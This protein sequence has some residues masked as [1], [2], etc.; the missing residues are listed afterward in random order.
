MGSKDD[1][2]IS[3]IVVDTREQLPLFKSPPAKRQKLDAGDYSVVGYETRIAVERKSIADLYG[4]FGKGR[5]RFE[6]SMRRLCMLPARLLVVEGSLADIRT[7]TYQGRVKPDVIY[8]SLLAW[9]AIAY[10]V[11][12]W[13]CENRATARTAVRSFLRLAV[14]ALDAI[15]ANRYRHGGRICIACGGWT[16]KHAPRCRKAAGYSV[17]RVEDMLMWAVPPV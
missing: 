9:C 3:R 16:T 15:E 13:P 10:Q 1:F 5:N 12:P 2:P 14:D 11:A 17:L 4:S 6:R 8:G 7:F